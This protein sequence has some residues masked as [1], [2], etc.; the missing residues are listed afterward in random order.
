MDVPLFPLDI[1]FLVI[2]IEFSCFIKVCLMFPLYILY[3]VL[4]STD[5][6]AVFLNNNN[7]MSIHVP[8]E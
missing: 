4:Q 2:T 6:G 1:K 3:S 7:L 8:V 5:Q